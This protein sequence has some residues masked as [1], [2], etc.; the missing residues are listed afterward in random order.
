MK[1]KVRIIW[2]GSSG[3][4]LKILYMRRQ[5]FQNC[6]FRHPPSRT[7]LLTLKNVEVEGRKFG[8]RSQFSKLLFLVHCMGSSSHHT[9]S[10]YHGGRCLCK[11]SSRLIE[12]VQMSWMFTWKPLLLSSTRCAKSTLVKVCPHLYANVNGV[13]GTEANPLSIHIND[14]KAIAKIH[15]CQP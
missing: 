6:N 2:N 3:V 5:N 9:W 14:G 12:H 15:L 7:H 11:A 4:Y 8:E 13:C 1:K 10:A